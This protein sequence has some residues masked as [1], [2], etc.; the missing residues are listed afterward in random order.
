MLHRLLVGK[1]PLPAK[2]RP[3]RLLGNISGAPPALEESLRRW[4]DSEGQGVSASDV[5]IEL[6]AIIDSTST[7][8]WS[9]APTT[10]ARVVERTSMIMLGDEDDDE[11]TK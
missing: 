5:A 2:V 9:G 6:K 8:F 10:G 4:L 7:E 1:P 3:A 11:P